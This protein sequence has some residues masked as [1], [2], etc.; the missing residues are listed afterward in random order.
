L[1]LK[2]SKLRF[3]SY[4]NSQN[5]D[6]TD[7]GSFGY[8]FQKNRVDDLLSVPC[9]V[10]KKRLKHADLNEMGQVSWRGLSNPTVPSP[11]FS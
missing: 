8:F 3:F 9:A 4:H 6:K 5:L 11:C 2:E 7:D 1:G 10:K